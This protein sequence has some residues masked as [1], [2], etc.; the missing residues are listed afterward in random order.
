MRNVE[1]L[2]YWRGVGCCVSYQYPKSI[3]RMDW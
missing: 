2:I 1:F 3:D